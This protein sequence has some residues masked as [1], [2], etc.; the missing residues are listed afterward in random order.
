MLQDLIGS[1]SLCN[2]LLHAGSPL[3][4]QGLELLACSIALLYL[5]AGFTNVILR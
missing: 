5:L 3:Q 1:E 2:G 4:K